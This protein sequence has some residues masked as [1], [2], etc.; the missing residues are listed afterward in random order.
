MLLIVQVACL[1]VISIDVKISIIIFISKSASSFDAKLITFDS[2]LFTFLHVRLESLNELVDKSS[3]F[4][5]V[6]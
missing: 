6:T 5:D 1:V 4:L 3:E 2:Q